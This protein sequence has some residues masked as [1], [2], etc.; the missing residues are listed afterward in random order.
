MN[1]R[2]TNRKKYFR[3]N[4]II[5]LKEPIIISKHFSE[6]DQTMCIKVFVHILL[7]KEGDTTNEQ[8]KRMNARN[9]SKTKPKLKKLYFDK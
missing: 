4:L 6:V 1:D 2:F 3:N 8:V 5:R 9:R 7:I